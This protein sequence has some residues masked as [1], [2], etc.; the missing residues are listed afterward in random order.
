MDYVVADESSAVFRAGSS[1][2]EAIIVRLDIEAREIENVYPKNSSPKVSEVFL[3]QPDAV[4][5]PTSNG[6]YSYGLYYPPKNAV[7]T[8]PEGYL[9]PLIVISHGGPTGAAQSDLDLEIQYWTSRG[10]GIFDVNYGGSTGYGRDYRKRLNG[11]WGIVDVED[12]VNGALF[13]AREK[14]VDEKMLIIRGG[15]AGG[16][17]TLCALTFS[18]AFKAGASYFGI[19][20]LE[21]FAGETHKFESR[22]LDLL[23]GPFPQMRDVYR[24]RSPIHYLDNI[25]T[26]II[27]FQGLEDKIVP[28]NQAET[29]FQALKKKGIPTAYLPFEGEQH[30]FRQAKRH[31]SIPRGRTVFLRASF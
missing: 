9:P 4:K 2:S 22:Y 10:F 27:F 30:G 17:T 18:K 14:K 5:F 15:S 23:I 25:S 13:L 16:Y 26:P 6:L 19:S 1:I 7:N 29:M 31:C 20:D 3:S 8:G 24:K 21:S 11:Q 28:P 12:C